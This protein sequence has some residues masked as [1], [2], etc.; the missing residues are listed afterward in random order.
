M[1]ILFLARGMPFNLSSIIEVQLTEPLLWII[2]TAPIF[3]GLFASFVGRREDQLRQAYV[4]LQQDEQELQELTK[5]LQWRKEQLITSSDISSRLS[6]ILNL[7]E[8]LS[9]VVNQIKDRFGY[10]YAHIYLLD[11]K[12]RKLVMAEGTGTAGA[13]MKAQGHHV[14]L[15]A[16]GPVARAARMGQIIWIDNVRETEDWLPNPLL[17]NTYSE[18][19][20]PIILEGHVVG[21]LDVQEDKIAG[22]D[23]GDA[24][25]LRSLANQVAVAIRNARL[26]AEVETALDEA[27]AVQEQYL[28]QSWQKTKSVSDKRQYLYTGSDA[29]SLDAVKR[30]VITK[31]RQQALIQKQPALVELGDENSRTE[32]VVAPINLRDRTIGTLQLHAT[33][34]DDQMW[35]DDDLALLEAVIDQLA[36]T[37]EN[38]RLFEET[39][40]Q[41]GQEQAIRKITDRLRAAPNLNTLLETAARELGQRLGVRHTVLELGIESDS[42]GA[43]MSDQQE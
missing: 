34:G 43:D 9:S 25:L 17:P 33:R 6:T 2:D 28:A 3:L 16:F 15:E 20:V 30:Q 31:A 23:D 29:A 42:N 7:E 39:R 36:Q 18:M 13:E 12:E 14:A 41:A 19:A 10:Y 1:G 24:D 8:L 26:F 40:Q 38:L 4:Y 27:R 22:L 21:V 35:N 37:A 5:Q 32:S 11:E